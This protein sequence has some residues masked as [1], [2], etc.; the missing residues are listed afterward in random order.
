MWCLSGLVQGVRVRFPSGAVGRNAPAARQ[1]EA[2]F[3]DHRLLFDVQRI[4]VAGV[5]QRI[6]IGRRAVPGAQ[7]AGQQI[8][9]HGDLPDVGQFVNEGG[10][11]KQWPHR[12]VLRQGPARP[13]DPVA[14]EPAS[15]HKGA[16]ERP[17]RSQDPDPGRIEGVAEHL[18]R[19]VGLAR[20][21]AA[22]HG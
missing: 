9:S 14:S 22:D 17:G 16:D 13:D 2:M 1:S 6:M 10:L 5:T 20:G 8:D 18:Q 3:D 11:S 21:Q 4:P 19:Q 12:Q 15:G 7:L